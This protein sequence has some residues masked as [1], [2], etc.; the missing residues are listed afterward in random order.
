[1]Y[2]ARDLLEAWMNGRGGGCEGAFSPLSAASPYS[3][4]FTQTSLSRWKCARKGRREGPYPSH[5]PLRF[6]TSPSPLPAK[7]DAPEEE[8]GAEE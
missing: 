5:G 2:I 8:A 6:I 1:M 3:Y 4:E 7:N